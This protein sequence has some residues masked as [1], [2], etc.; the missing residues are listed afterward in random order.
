[1]LGIHVDTNQTVAVGCSKRK[2]IDKEE[3]ASKERK[4]D[5]EKKSIPVDSVAVV[6]PIKIMPPE[7]P[8][9]EPILTVAKAT[10][11]INEIVWCKIRGFKIWPSRI[12][13]DPSKRL[14]EVRWFNDYRRSKVIHTQHFKFLPNFNKYASIFDKTMGL[15]TAVRE[16]MI[17][18]GQDMNYDFCLRIGINR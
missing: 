5:D 2:R 18:L 9:D 1:M 16:A 3:S 7:R 4:I 8:V 12:V 11:C 14:I 15:Q 17:E 10:F 6:S 13:S